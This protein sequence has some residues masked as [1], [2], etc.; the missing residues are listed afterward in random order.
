[1]IF[2]IVK[3]TFK[4]E[5]IEDFKSVFGES[6]EYIRSFPGNMGL[7]LLQSCEDKNVFF[8][9]SIWQN[10]EAL[11]AYRNSP[12][13]DSTWAKTKVLFG[14]KPEAWST[15]MIWKDLPVN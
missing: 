11:Q 15:D 7:Q 12:L 4:P 2:R 5:T 9:Y 1:M 14:G 10:D 6:A 3:M 13:F 8:T